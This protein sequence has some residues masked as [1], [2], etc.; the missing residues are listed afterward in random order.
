MLG[1][2]QKPFLMKAKG[3][4]FFIQDALLMTN[5]VH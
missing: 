4:I 1:E 5:Y 3:K 2:T